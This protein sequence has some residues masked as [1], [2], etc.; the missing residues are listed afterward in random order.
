MYWGGS[1]LSRHKSHTERLAYINH[2]SNFDLHYSFRPRWLGSYEIVVIGH[3]KKS[4][5]IREKDD[6][7]ALILIDNVSVTKSDDLVVTAPNTIHLQPDTELRRINVVGFKVDAK[8]VYDISLKLEGMLNNG[9]EIVATS[10]PHKHE[11]YLTFAMLLKTLSYVS[12][13]VGVV[14]VAQRIFAAAQK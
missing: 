14:V 2:G 6:T 5:I 11:D 13:F 9:I 3:F 12:L 7:S 1:S 4:K 8:T 10:D